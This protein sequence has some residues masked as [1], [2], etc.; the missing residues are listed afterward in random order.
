M[1]KIF[2]NV[3]AAVVTGAF[4]IGCT[5]DS[6]TDEMIT[7]NATASTVEVQDLTVND[8]VGRWNMYTMT[9]SDSVDFDSNEVYTY[10]LLE[11]TDCFDPMF[12]VFDVE[13]NVDTEQARLFFDGVTG[14]FTC[15]TTGNYSATYTISGNELTV[16][17]QVDGI[18]YT[19]T[20]TVSRYSDNGEE[21]LQ[22]TL[23][24]AETDAA[25][26]IAD[27]P[28]NTVA[29]DIQKIEMVYIKEY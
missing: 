1:N 23:T 8:L 6:I 28:G 16:N 11:E 22:V 27:D 20:K 5:A 2:M 21:F 14:E 15:F 4:L 17:F 9:S 19:E 25:V 3:L 29:S 18:G 13:G 24:K 10:D 12:F 26:Y 7:L